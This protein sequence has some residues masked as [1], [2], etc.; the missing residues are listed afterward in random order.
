MAIFRVTYNV[1]EKKGGDLY[2]KRQFLVQCS[3]RKSLERM[4]PSKEYTPE[5]NAFWEIQPFKPLSLGDLQLAILAGDEG[6]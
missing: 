5:L 6:I 3:S 1:R 2:V 4:V